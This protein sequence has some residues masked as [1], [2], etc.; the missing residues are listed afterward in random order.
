MDDGLDRAAGLILRPAV[1]HRLELGVR[2]L[3][4]EPLELSG[5]SLVL[6]HQGADRAFAAQRRDLAARAPE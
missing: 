6:V 4:D 1:A 2:E 3:E 5:S